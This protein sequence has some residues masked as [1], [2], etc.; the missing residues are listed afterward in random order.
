MRSAK[1]I[2]SHVEY[3]G[4]IPR[5]ESIA[6]TIGDRD[7][8]I[9]ESR[10]ATDTHVLATPLA[11]IYDRSVITLASPLPD[12]ALFAMFL[13]W[14]RTRYDRVLFMGGG[15]TDLL[16]PSWDAK[17]I[18]SERFQIPE[19]DAPVDAY[20]RFVRRKEFDF[21]IYELTRPDPATAARPFDLDVGFQDDLQVVRF[22]AKQETDGHTYRWSR[23]PSYV[24]VTRVRA[25]AR[26]IELWLSNGGRPDAAGQ[27][28]VT[29]SLDNQVLG[30][31]RV[32]DGFKPYTVAI[33]PAL[34]Q[35]IAARGQPVQ[36]KLACPVWVPQ[37]VIGGADGRDLGVMVDRVA[38][39]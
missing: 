38:I 9:V 28:D 26:E 11:Y 18:A 22:H 30:T 39:K 5:L 20:P 8:L 1:P 13:E 6:H 34:A 24:G 25:D 36:I 3:A 17:A 21:G 15:G 19:Y 4:L 23:N 7:L 35:A 29:V 32:A 10:N 33:P 37:A 16:S 27:A 2:L 31:V 14:A 12:K